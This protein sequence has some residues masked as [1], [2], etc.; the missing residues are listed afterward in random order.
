MPGNLDSLPV[1][2]EAAPSADL[3]GRLVG[4][5]ATPVDANLKGKVPSKFYQM[6]ELVMSGPGQSTYVKVEVDRAAV[7]VTDDVPFK[8]HIVEPNAPLVQN[9]SM[10]LKIV[11]ERKPGFKAPITILA[12]FNPPGVGSTS[13]ATIA[14]N[15]TET[16]FPMNAAGNAPPRKWK[17]AVVGYATVGN[18]PVYVSSQLATIEVAAPFVGLA[19]ERAAVEQGKQAEIFCK[20]QNNTPFTGPAKVTLVGLPNKV[21]TTPM[22]ITKD[23][24]EL[25]FKLTTD[26]TSP[27][28]THRNLFCQVVVMVNGEPVLHNVGSSELR[29]DV[30]LPPKVAAAPPPATAKPQPAAQPAK[31]PE[32]RLTRLEKLRLEQE[33]RAKTGG[34][35]PAT[36]K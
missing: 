17:Y 30:P 12:L 9:G 33:E 36:K 20:V 5:T 31:P 6:A 28:G 11:A 34:G 19:M 27:A 24:K 21:T 8:I 1:V 3:S 26:K 14:E 29:I 22:D 10:N 16:L 4:L 2:F 18:G 35:T 25:S 23:T 15:A 32:K 13:S 7:A